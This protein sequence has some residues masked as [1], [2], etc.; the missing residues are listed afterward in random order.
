MYDKVERVLYSLSKDYADLFKDS[1]RFKEI[2][3]Q[4]P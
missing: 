4:K 2:I 3:K 1:F